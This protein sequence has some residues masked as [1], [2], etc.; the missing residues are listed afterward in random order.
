M[1]E[2]DSHI[3]HD[4]TI[5]PELNL[6]KNHQLEL[7]L[8]PRLMRLLDYFLQH[9]NEIVTKDEL[10]EY[11]W[12]DRLVTDNLLTK[13]IS[14]L[15]KVLK[16]HFG[17]SIQIETLRNVGYRLIIDIE[18]EQTK[19]VEIKTSEKTIAPTSFAFNPWW[20]VGVALVS[21]MMIWAARNDFAVAE[22]N[23]TI[24]H[25]KLTGLQGLEM[26]PAISP[27]GKNIAFIWNKNGQGAPQLYVR[28]LNTNQP[29]LVSQVEAS[30]YSPLWSKDGTYLYYF[31]IEKAGEWQLM[32]NSVI[33]TEEVQ[34][35]ILKL[36]SVGSLRWLKADEELLFSGMKSEGDSR[37]LF[38]FNVLTNRLQQITQPPAGIYGD[39]YPTTLP[40]S[41]T[42]AFVRAQMGESIFSNA[43]PVQG[44]ILEFNINNKQAKRIAE[45][46]NEINSFLYHE[47]LERYLFW[48][49]EQLGEY[50][51]WELD[52]A[53][54]LQT[55]TRTFNGMPR[56]AAYLDDNK[57]CYEYWRSIVDVNV[58]PLTRDSLQLV[59]YQPFLKSTSWDW[60]IDFAKNTNQFAF[61]SQRSG[62][63]EI[64]LST[65]HQ[66]EQARPLTQLESPLL[67]SLA[68]SP[69]GRQIV[70]CSVKNN[71][72]QLYLLPTNGQAIK[73]LTE[74]DADYAAPEWSADGK[75]IYYS[76]NRSGTWQL[77]QYDL[78]THQVKP[79]TVNGGF[80]A[81]P[82][83][84]NDAFLYFVKY[85]ENSL[86]QL[87]LKTKT[88]TLVAKLSELK[89][90]LNWAMTPDGIYYIY[91]REG[92]SYLGFYNLANRQEQQVRLLE[93]MIVG[94][95]AL[96]IAPDFKTIYIAQGQ[97]LNADILGLELMD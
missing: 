91:W 80:R 94:I 1:K 93:N 21:I 6:L 59:D 37:A 62:Y 77:Y 39:I 31:R 19:I 68:L 95:P 7:V 14:E 16:E 11:G 22:K 44:Q 84:K 71:Q 96:A 54:N 46:P 18:E 83:P 75:H 89:H 55:V 69:D 58:Y 85:D 79:L 73:K 28:P 23:W 42:I 60:G 70:F 36:Y 52:R 5:H 53:G 82:D 51:I 33:G 10:L 86:W 9:K 29:R 40:D 56:N 57:I 78:S 90:S 61:F 41:E 63:S 76:S 35:S 47:G 88:T 4:W 15:R 92:Q 27:N 34:L 26:Q 13:S 74:D 8:Q 81:L 48:G 12:E 66:P 45:L 49:T 67:K 2:N 38:Q 17:A 87:D 30:E 64:W 32:R 72:S 97:G 25:S 65:T 3:L 20:L 50:Q 24:K 43:A